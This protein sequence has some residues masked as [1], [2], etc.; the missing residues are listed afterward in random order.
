MARAGTTVPQ[1]VGPRRMTR[2]KAVHGRCLARGRDPHARRWPGRGALRFTSVQ[3]S[4]PPD[5]GEGADAARGGARPAPGVVTR[6]PER[7]YSYAIAERQA[8][9][10]RSL[11]TKERGI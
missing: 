2:R 8:R 7:C 9:S 4:A 5:D 1:R 10:I 3:V 6:P 11:L